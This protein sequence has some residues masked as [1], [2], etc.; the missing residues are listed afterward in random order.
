MPC[1]DEEERLEAQAHVV[2]KAD[3]ELAKARRKL[4]NRLK[5]A[6]GTCVLGAA[7]SFTGLA[8]LVSGGTACITTLLVADDA[9][10][11]YEY[12]L[13][14]SE[15]EHDRYVDL[16]IDQFKCLSNCAPHNSPANS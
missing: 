10:A 2:D 5:V 1:V 15:L 11:D 7:A 4:K 3:A 9:A 12:A 8:G 6:G 14:I 16:L 13:E